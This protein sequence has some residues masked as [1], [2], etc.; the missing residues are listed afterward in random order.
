MFFY[1][2]LCPLQGLGSHKTNSKFDSN[3][4]DFSH[5]EVKFVKVHS[6]KMASVKMCQNLRAK[7]GAHGHVAALLTGGVVPAAY[8][9]C[10]QGLVGRFSHE[11]VMESM[12]NS[13]GVKRGEH[14]GVVMQ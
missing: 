13:K 5:G 14:G 3:Q 11:E 2:P 1:L 4:H 10:I 7:L 6:V 8:A 12:A 9:P